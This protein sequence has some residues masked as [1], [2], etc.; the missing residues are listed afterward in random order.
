[1]GAGSFAPDD[2]RV[3]GRVLGFAG[4]VIR[5]RSLLACACFLCAVDERSGSDSR[6]GGGRERKDAL[7]AAA[8]ALQG[9]GIKVRAHLDVWERELARV[10]DAAC[11]K[12]ER[13]VHALHE[14][15]SWYH[16][17]QVP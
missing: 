1:M 12:F 3:L 9:R 7:A 8:C 17:M 6:G 14:W 4:D 10:Y 15:P 16:D 5:P 13:L 11:V 2:A